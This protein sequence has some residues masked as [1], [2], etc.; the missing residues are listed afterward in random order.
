MRPFLDEIAGRLREI[1]ARGLQ[2][3]LSEPEGVDF[4]SNDYLGI[5]RHPLLR[6]RLAEAI[7]SDPIS[8]PASRLLGGH[9]PEHAAL[10]ERLARFKG[11]EAALLFPSGYQANLA[12]LTALIGPEDLAVSDER[13]HASIIDGL[14]LSGCT[15]AIYPHLDLGA[16]EHALR[17]RPPRGRA[18][19][20]TESLFSMDGDIAPLDEVA[21]I[22]ERCGAA[23]IVDDAHA[24]GVFGDERGSGLCER[25][26][27]EK[28]TSAIVST[29]G[30]ALGLSG[31]FV[32]GPSLVIEYLI[33]KA[34]PFIFTTAPL[35]LLAAAVHAALDIVTGEPERRRR[36]LDLA[37]RLR[38]TLRTAGI[39]TPGSSGPIVPVVLGENDRA[40]RVAERVRR[41][42]HGV[43]AIR[44]PSV[45]PGTARLRISVHADHTEAEVDALARAIAEAALFTLPPAERAEPAVA[46]P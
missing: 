34:R 3:G 28:R 44:P 10:E 40:L 9:L 24:T 32:T 39:D 27:I 2:R 46:A 29:F 41:G 16:A 26:G 21:G 4:S 20:V 11:T 13:N 35:P 17:S 19:I 36:V 6:S 33:N 38:G 31:A 14:R 30:K 7:Q 8:A 42:G 43:R 12:V 18:F 25:F 22:A 23:L 37:D 1:E 5:S 45:A 15:K